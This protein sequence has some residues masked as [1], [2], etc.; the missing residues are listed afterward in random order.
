MLAA[1]YHSFLFFYLIHIQWTLWMI[2]GMG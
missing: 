2:Y 1:I